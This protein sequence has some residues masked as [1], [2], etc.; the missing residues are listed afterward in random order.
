MIDYCVER[1]GEENV[2]RISTYSKLQ[3]KSA[4]LEVARVSE[5]SDMAHI[6]HITKK[7]AQ[8]ITKKIPTLAT[9]VEKAIDECPEFKQWYSDNKNRKWFDKYVEP[10][11]GLES[12]GG[13]NAAGIVIAPK[14]IAEYMPLKLQEKKKEKEDAQTG[15]KRLKVTQFDGDSIEAIGLLKFDVLGLNTL[16]SLNYTKILLEKR[17]GK[18]ISYPAISLK[19][20]KFLKGFRDGDTVGIFQFDTPGSTALVKQVEPYSFFEVM[21]SSSLSRPGTAGPGLDMEYCRRKKGAPFRYDHPLLEPILNKTYGVAPFQE[22][23]MS[24][25]NIIGGL[26]L[27]EADKL[28]KTMK[29]KDHAEMRSYQEKFIIGALERGCVDRED[30]MKIWDTVESWSKYGFPKCLTGETVLLRSSGNQHQDREITI[31]QLYKDLHSNTPVGGKYRQ[32]GL[33][34]VL[35]LVDGKIKTDKIKDIWCNGVRNVYCIKTI[36]GYSVKATGNHRFLTSAGWIQLKNIHIGTKISLYNE[37]MVR[38]YIKKGYNKERRGQGST[39][40]NPDGRPGFPKGKNNPGYID[41][42]GILWKK[43]S[44]WVVDNFPVCQEC[45]ADRNL[46]IHHKD[47]QYLYNGDFKKF[48]NRKN[49]IRLCSSCHKKAEYKLGINKRWQA[50]HDIFLG[51]VKSVEFCG[52]EI[53]Y[54]IEMWGQGHNF[55][56]NGFISHNSH[57]ASYSQVSMWC[58]AM[59]KVAP[60]EFYAGLLQ[61]AHKKTNTK[62]VLQTVHK[63]IMSHGYQIVMPNVNLSKKDYSIHDGKIVW[64]LLG[65]K[66]VGIPPSEMIPMH[67]P[68]E[69]IEDLM[70]KVPKKFCNKGVMN[71][72]IFADAF[73]DIYPTQYD[74]AAAYYA[75]RKEELP[76]MFKSTNEKYWEKM[77]YTTVDFHRRD[78]YELYEST[79]RGLGYYPLDTYEEYMALHMTSDAKMGGYMTEVKVIKSKH[80]PMALMKMETDYETVSLVAW[81]SFFS[82]NKFLRTN[83]KDLVGKY[84]YI[85]GQKNMSPQWGDQITLSNND[86][87]TLDVIG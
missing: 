82:K 17:I 18:K 37:K 50:G 24:I 55:V 67:A 40:K 14:P 76:E 4:I 33:P 5:Y 2:A 74:A 28:R 73:S 21:N 66:N 85:F 16:R 80:G 61:F 10:L 79:L 56:A 22:N 35:S 77:F 30:A 70:S 9:T 31:E 1:Y 62:K 20:D 3:I 42:R 8:R 58:M 72:L 71:S 46:E 75:L 34:V 26:T 27:V 49:L 86:V 47:R 38:Y 83:P 64:S 63:D 53:T 65:V 44:A 25:V 87:E 81:N 60:L 84:V 29:K 43:N 45:G 11:L 54:D 39:Y 57:A 6:K 41:G 7:E 48:H 19:N 12:H 52:K 36:E 68:Y 15:E 32:F 23:I 59:K 78:P 69:S 13:I 51:T